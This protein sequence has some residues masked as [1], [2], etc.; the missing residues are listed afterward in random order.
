MNVATAKAT[1]KK[2][3]A[4]TAKITGQTE[5]DL[6]TWMQ[7]KCAEKKDECTLGLLCDI[8]DELIEL[9]ELEDLNSWRILNN[10]V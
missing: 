10:A 7:G 5:L 1:M 9:M 2:D 3:I 8:K 4:K 6:I